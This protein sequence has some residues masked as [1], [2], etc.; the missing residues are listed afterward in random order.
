MAEAPEHIEKDDIEKFIVTLKHGHSGWPRGRGATIVLSRVTIHC[1]ESPVRL[2]ERIHKNTDE[3]NHAEKRFFN[4]LKNEINRLQNDEE[5]EINKIEVILVQN[6]SPCHKCVD[7]EILE[8]KKTHSKTFFLTVKFANIYGHYISKNIEGLKI[9]LR[10]HVSL[11]LL[12]G[13]G[14]WKS[15]LRDTTFVRLDEDEY[16]ELLERATSDERVYREKEDKKMLAG[17]KSDAQSK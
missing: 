4:Y 2:P 10:N 17:I 7:E 13:E 9:L 14:E 1:D 6:Y 5:V 3:N 11:E 12:Q 16:N 15:F 8:F